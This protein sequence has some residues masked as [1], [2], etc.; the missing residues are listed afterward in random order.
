ML[1]NFSMNTVLRRTPFKVLRWFLQDVGIN[2]G[3]DW[4]TMHAY[5]LP[6]V[7]AAYDLVPEEQKIK[8]EIVVREIVALA[9]Q[10][11][12]AAIREAAKLY[13]LSYLDL[14]FKAH[15]SAYL[16]AI[17]VW[18]EHRDVFAKAQKL[19]QVN[20]ASFFRKRSGLPT[21]KIPVTEERLNKLK[22]ELQIFFGAKQNRGR[23]CTVELFERGEGRYCVVAYP[24]DH[25]IPYLEHNQEA[26]LVP[27]MVNPV[28]EIV[29]D[30]NSNEGT[31]ALSAQLEKTVKE[32]LENLFIRTIY[33][34]EPPP[35]IKP[36]YDIEK[37]KDSQFMLATETSDCL[38]AEISHMD[39]LWKD[40]A[41][42]SSFGVK[43]KGNIF[44]PIN[45]L[46][47]KEKRNL[48]DAEVRQ[49]TIRFHFKPKRGRRAGVLCVELTPHQMVIRCKDAVRIE[50]MLKY[51]KKWEV[52]Q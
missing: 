36:D 27:V 33:E 46:L 42:V 21:G 20:R 13:G 50:T 23:V 5:D 48:N 9:D 39:L 45:T 22:T 34:I 12:I 31:L 30:I 6:K 47:R 16:Q 49:V 2:L 26:I 7:I 35:L 44:C 18:T 40:I 28:F 3:F 37:L 38:Q 14:I 32:E 8:A 25:P 24:D 15:P 4:D 29:F 52:S 43:K 10:E 51:L 11:G 1:K 41:S 19:L 17:W